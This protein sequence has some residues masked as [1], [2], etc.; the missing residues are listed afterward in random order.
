MENLKG[1]HKNHSIRSTPAQNTGSSTAMAT[2]CVCFM[3]IVKDLW[4]QYLPFLHQQF[5][6]KLHFFD[7]QQQT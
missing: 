1:G 7:K 4:H 3:N 5:V 6:Q 2:F